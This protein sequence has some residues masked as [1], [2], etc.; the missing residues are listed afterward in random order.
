MLKNNH[1]YWLYSSIQSEKRCC[2]V[3]VISK[4]RHNHKTGQSSDEGGCERNTF[5]CVTF[6]FDP[7]LSCNIAGS[8]AYVTEI[9]SGVNWN[10]T[11]ENSIIANQRQKLCLFDKLVKMKIRK[12][13]CK[14]DILRIFPL[15]KRTGRRVSFVFWPWFVCWLPAHKTDITCETHCTIITRGP[16]LVVK[17]CLGHGIWQSPPGE[18]MV[19]FLEKEMFIQIKYSILSFLI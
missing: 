17:T 18:L 9:K 7:L 1:H 11:M 19:I 8:V 3:P 6:W 5:M 10:S 15:D 16:W 13:T 14:R 4:Y 2:F 12:L